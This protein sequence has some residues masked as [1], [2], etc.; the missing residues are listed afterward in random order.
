MEILTPMDL[1]KM[2]PTI[3]L[4]DGER[5]GNWVYKK[6]MTLVYKKPKH[7]EYEIDLEGCTT[8]WR[9]LD[10]VFHMQ[11]KNWI[12]DQDL[13][14]LTWAFRD[15]LGRSTLQGGEIPNIKKHLKERTFIKHKD[16]EEYTTREHDE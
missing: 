14:D 3:K 2:Y 16:S 7:Y 15:I 13:A 6:N 4:V 12:T 10:W 8:A 1:F 9:A 11:G 5:W